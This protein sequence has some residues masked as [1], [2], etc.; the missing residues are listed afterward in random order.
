MSLDRNVPCIVTSHSFSVRLMDTFLNGYERIVYEMQ[1]KNIKFAKYW[2][3][4]S[5]ESLYFH[6]SYLKAYIINLP[7]R[8]TR[9]NTHTHTH[10]HIYI[11]IYI[12]KMGLF[13]FSISIVLPLS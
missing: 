5:S 1:I 3:P 11:Y 10:T 4:F 7:R 6:V 12:S 13:K 2:L 8:Y 9:R